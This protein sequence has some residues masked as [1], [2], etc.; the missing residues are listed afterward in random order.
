[1]NR[2]TL[3]KTEQVTVYP[4]GRMDTR[5]TSNYL[6][7]SEKTLAMMRC[8]GTGPRYVKRGRIFYYLEDLNTWLNAA[9][10]FTS[11]AEAQQK[12]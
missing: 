12:I 9:G 10:R 11:T 5:N 1:M 6:G 4:D 7:I 8:K 2:P 3:Y